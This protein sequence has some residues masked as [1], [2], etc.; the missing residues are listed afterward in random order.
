MGS[1]VPPADRAASKFREA[2]LE[3]HSLEDFELFDFAE[4][5]QDEQP[6]A[7][8]WFMES[9]RLRR[10]HFLHLNRELAGWKKRVQE[11]RKVSV[12]D[13]EAIGKVLR[14]QGI[15]SRTRASLTTMH[16]LIRVIPKQPQ[17]ATSN[18][19]AP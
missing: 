18:S 16:L 4:A 19:S 15:S 2:I 5:L 3:S 9:T 12:E 1:R 17:F 13:I 7:E 8:P 11:D 14:E 6:P 10:I